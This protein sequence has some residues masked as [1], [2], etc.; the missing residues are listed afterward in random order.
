[1]SNTA[2]FSDYSNSIC[3]LTFLENETKLF[4]LKYDNEDSSGETDYTI[5]IYFSRMICKY[6]SIA[7][8]QHKSIEY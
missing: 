5:G 4:T 2:Y 6:A 1:M 8:N 3:T 7:I